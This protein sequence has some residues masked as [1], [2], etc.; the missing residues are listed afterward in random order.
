MCGGELDGVDS[1]S[2]GS[3]CTLCRGI[4]F[5]SLALQHG[6]S[7]FR[8]SLNKISERACQGCSSVNSWD[9]V[10]FGEILI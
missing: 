9:H 3:C 8:T 6:R 2:D 1:V 5:K 4:Q 7:N 10:K